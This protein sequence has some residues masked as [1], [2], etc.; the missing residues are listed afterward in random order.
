[1]FRLSDGDPLKKNAKMLIHVC[2][3]SALFV[4]HLLSRSRCST[5]HAG[6]FVKQKGNDKIT[7]ISIGAPYSLGICP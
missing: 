5:H 4:Y 2:P 6:S 1:M 7:M 3:L